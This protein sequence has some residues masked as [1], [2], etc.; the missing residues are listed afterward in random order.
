MFPSEN[1]GTMEWALYK[2]FG[3]RGEYERGKV[4]FEQ[5]VAT[6][7]TSDNDPEFSDFANMMILGLMA[8]EKSNITR[9][10]ADLMSSSSVYGKELVNV[11]KTV[12]N[13]AE[14]YQKGISPI[15]ERSGWNFINTDDTALLNTLPLGILRISGPRPAPGGTLEA[16]WQRG[17]VN[18]GIRPDRPGFAVLDE[19]G[20]WVG[21]DVEFCTALAAGALEGEFRA[22]DFIEIKDEGD[23][24]QK[25]Q[26]GDVDVLAGFTVSIRSATRDV[27]VGHGGHYGEF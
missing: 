11:V 12:G 21:M 27:N 10:T 23:G 1:S 8:A 16:I 17:K 24:Y 2:V 19:N 18:C 25:L 14:V 4:P 22:I 3:Y 20:A 15:A 13:Y 7:C 26:A 6:V 5:D 9:E